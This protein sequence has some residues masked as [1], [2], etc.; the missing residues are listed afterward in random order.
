MLQ[1]KLRAPV[2]VIIS[3]LCRGLVNAG[4]RANHLTVIGAIGSC[5]FA[6]F[7]FPRGQ[8]IVGTILVALFALLDLL[9]GTVA[10][11]TDEIPSKWGALL[12]STVDRISDAVIVIGIAIYLDNN[13]NIP[14]VVPFLVVLLS[15]LV[16]YVRARSESLGIQCAVGVGERTERLIIILVGTFLF[17]IGIDGALEV[18]LWLVLI[19]STLTVFQRLAVVFRA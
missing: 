19:I 4:V 13:R 6:L 12:D 16:S 1:H 14:L 3:P 10:R 5:F 18:S 8:F 2:S 7:F 17:G 9:D 15:G 11:M